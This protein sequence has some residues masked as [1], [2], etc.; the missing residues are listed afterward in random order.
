M[1]SGQFDLKKP[2]AYL[3]WLYRLFSQKTKKNIYKSSLSRWD[4][5]LFKILILSFPNTSHYIF[6]AHIC[7]YIFPNINFSGNYVVILD[8]ERKMAWILKLLKILKTCFLSPNTLVCNLVE[9]YTAKKCFSEVFGWF[10][11][12]FEKIEISTWRAKIWQK[13]KISSKNTITSRW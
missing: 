12:I 10:L 9:Y 4:F 6:Y 13:K 8:V 11:C 2:Q 1:F 3:G 5:F 7:W